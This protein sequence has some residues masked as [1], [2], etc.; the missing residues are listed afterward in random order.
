MFPPHSSQEGGG[1]GRRQERVDLLLWW[2]EEDDG[3]SRNEGGID[4]DHKT[5]FTP[6]PWTRLDQDPFTE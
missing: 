1:S 4:Y 2:V 6:E 5:F 3:K